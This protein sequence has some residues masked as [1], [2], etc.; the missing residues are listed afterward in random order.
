MVSRRQRRVADLIHEELST[1]LERKV[2]DPRLSG[3]TITAVEVSA[4]LK[5][6]T[7]H[8]SIL[9]EEDAAIEAAQV[10]LEHASGFLRKGLADVLSMR[11]VPALAFRIDKSLRRGQ[12]IEELL[13]SLKDSE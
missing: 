13:K 1:M 5:L 6:A 2:A 9:S 10:G 11:L 7:V 8:Y 3:V 12:R 4:D